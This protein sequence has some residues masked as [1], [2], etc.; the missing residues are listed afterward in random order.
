MAKNFRKKRDGVWKK[1]AKKKAS[2]L[3]SSGGESRHYTD[4]SIRRGG[5]FKPVRRRVTKREIKNG[6]TVLKKLTRGRVLIINHK[7]GNKQVVSK[8]LKGG[9]TFINNT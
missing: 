5:F 6:Y 8:N 4:R 7:T 9:I 2:L 3:S 1:E